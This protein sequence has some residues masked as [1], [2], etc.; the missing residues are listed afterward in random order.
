MKSAVIILCKEHVPR[1]IAIL[2]LILNKCLNIFAFYCIRGKVSWKKGFRVKLLSIK[3][4]KT[5]IA[6]GETPT[7]QNIMIVDVKCESYIFFFRLMSLAQFINH[8]KKQADK[9]VIGT[10]HPNT[11]AL[12][13]GSLREA[14]K[15]VL[16]LMAGPLRPNSPPPLNLNGRK[17]FGTLEKNKFFFP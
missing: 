2:Q 7:N 1:K 6:F 8:E 13:A 9:L 10:K 4:L 16:L 3:V 15:K 11:F 12:T 17:N 14:A 5:T